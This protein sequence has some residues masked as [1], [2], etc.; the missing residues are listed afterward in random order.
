MWL[1]RLVGLTWKGGA[2]LRGEGRVFNKKALQD[3][4]SDGTP[5]M[6]C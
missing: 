6:A 3:V 2:Q 1:A 5:T 4:D